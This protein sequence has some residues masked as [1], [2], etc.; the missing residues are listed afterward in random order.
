MNNS[1]PGV[2]AEV[3]GQPLR[4]APLAGED[5]GTL[6]LVRDQSTSEPSVPSI[7][8][9]DGGERWKE[10]ELAEVCSARSED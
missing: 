4:D 9:V 7:H 1:R 10:K 5:T 8:L 6:L 2:G 3:H